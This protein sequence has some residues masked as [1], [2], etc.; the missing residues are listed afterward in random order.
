MLN[1]ECSARASDATGR[2]ILFLDDHDLAAQ[3]GL[4]RVLHAASKHPANP[5]L[6]PEK[7]WEQEH[8]YVSSVLRDA[9]TGR[10]RLWYCVLHEGGGS[11]PSAR[12][13]CYAESDDG[14]HWLRPS[15][16]LVEYQGSKDNSILWQ[17]HAEDL[18]A[19]VVVHPS[20]PSDEYRY[21]GYAYDYGRSPAYLDKDG[22][23]LAHSPDGIHWADDRDLNPVIWSW[24]DVVYF[25]WDPLKR[26]FFGTVKNYLSLRGP[27]T[28]DAFLRRVFGFTES[29]DGIHWTQPLITLLPDEVD[30]A[31]A[32]RHQGQFTQFYGMPVAVYEGVYIG[33]L[34]VFRM[35]G[36]AAANNDGYV[37]L[38][39]CTSRDGYHWTRVGDRTPIL[40]RGAAGEFDHG[41]VYSTSAFLTMGDNLWLYYNG[42]PR[43]HAIGGPTRGGIAVWR[44]DGLVSLHADG[45]GEFVTVPLWTAGETLHVNANVAGSLAVEVLDEHGRIIPGYELAR[46]T[47]VTGDTTDTRVCWGERSRLALVHRPISLRVRLSHGD[48][49][50]LWVA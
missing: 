19:C 22:T 17:R 10:Y 14:V 11:D 16:G 27:T 40:V 2:R 49:Y 42:Q 15:L 39:L 44:R 50:S 32:D 12:L 18:L 43:Q 3:T 21:L 25:L 35:T 45:D 23:L 38:E 41:G 46:C 30:D 26:R 20:P 28:G 6:A 29:T 36:P 1:E 4:S 33:F 37:H 8:T 34:Q 31:W 9:S 48:I 47:P 24:A 5:V 13:P 7:P